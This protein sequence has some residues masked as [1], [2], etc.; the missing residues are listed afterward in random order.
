MHIDATRNAAGPVPDRERI[1]TLDV[2]RGAG[3]LGILVM[4][5]YAFAMPFMAYANPL[6][7]GG[8]EPVNMAT[9]FLTHILIDQKFM[10]IFSM[11][12]GAGVFLMAERAAAGGADATRLFLRRQLWLLVIGLVHAYLIW[13]G[14]ILT[15]Y[16]LI[17]PVVYLFRHAAPRALIAAACLALP[18]AVL[19]SYLGAIAVQDLEVRAQEISSRQAAGE[20]IGEQERETLDAWADARQVLLPGADE[21]EADLAAHRGSYADVLHYRAAVVLWLQL[22]GLPFFVLWRAGG[23]MLLGMALLKLGVLSGD[24][25]AGFYRGL[26]IGGYLLGLPLTIYSAV[27]AHAHAFDPI[28]MLKIGGIYNYVGSVFVALGHVGLVILIVRRGAMAKLTARLAAVGRMALTNYLMHSIVMTSLFYGYGLGLYGQIPRAGQM[29]FVA[30]LIGLQ[31][32]VSPWWL[33]RFRFGPAEWLWRSLA[34]GQPQS[35]RRIA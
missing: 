3:V 29:V 7:M 31:L 14:D 27:N 30:G 19:T 9:W 1:E 4:N 6:I 12:F 32:T 22:E 10:S 17:A 16:A 35:M 33:A 26:T 20:V 34:C 18:V 13:F 11:L 15:F 8:A 5:V 2:L 24:R 28:Y 21:L 25:T 23:L